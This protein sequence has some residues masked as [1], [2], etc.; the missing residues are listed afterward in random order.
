MGPWLWETLKNPALSRLCNMLYPPNWDQGPNSGDIVGGAQSFLCLNQKI[1]E[2]I[3]YRKCMKLTENNA[4]FFGLLLFC[5]SSLLASIKSLYLVG[6]YANGGYNWDCYAALGIARY[7]L[8]RPDKLGPVVDMYTQGF[9]HPLIYLPPL[10]ISE[11]LRVPVVAQDG[12]AIGIVYSLSVGLI[13]LLSLLVL[14]QSCNER[15]SII[16]SSAISLSLLWPRNI[17]FVSPNAEILGS[18]LIL[19]LI[20]TVRCG[21]NYWA[22][23]SNLIVVFIGILVFHLKYQLFPLS[24]A[25]IALLGA[26][27][28]R[29][30]SQLVVI[31]TFSSLLVD[32]LVYRLSGYGI[33]SRLLSFVHE[34]G[35]AGGSIT[36]SNSSVL[37]TISSALMV[38]PLFF[39][40]WLPLILRNLAKKTSYL[41]LRV[42]LVLSVI[43]L[44]SIA[45]PGKNFDH[46]YIIL[47]PVTVVLFSMAFASRLGA[48]SSSSTSFPSRASTRGRSNRIVL[49][50]PAY[51]LAIWGV[52]AVVGLQRHNPEWQTSLLLSDSQQIPGVHIY[53]W[54]NVYTYGSYGSYPSNPSI[55]E[56]L[57]LQ[58]FRKPPALYN[59]LMTDPVQM[60]ERIIDLAAIKSAGLLENKIKPVSEL[61]QVEG[62]HWSKAYRLVKKSPVG[63]LYEL[64]P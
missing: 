1:Y 21:T 47:L 18:I 24:L 57:A 34:Y 48:A 40:A 19:A 3:I 26:K 10:W 2:Q 41:S 22:K 36:K 56:S 50:T 61:Q 35:L 49:I 45:L 23:W 55:D 7:Y 63:Y 16:A 9:V 58:K 12:L 32:L 29:K 44:V 17:D 15:E 33:T 62:R 43:A 27:S 54:S 53:G 46:Y 11:L 13:A 42:P 59:K 5:S 31:V 25:I 52:L 38:Y 8:Y 39:V 14:R 4:G 64:T 30:R 60:P 28:I 51:L 20:Y 37:K 6:P